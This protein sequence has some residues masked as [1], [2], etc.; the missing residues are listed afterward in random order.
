MEVNLAGQDEPLFGEKR[1]IE[2]QKLKTNPPLSE[3]IRRLVN[4]ELYAVLCTQMQGQPYGSLVAFAFSD[5]LKYAVFCTPVA[6]RKFRALSECDR[7]AVV[8]DSRV[9]HPDDM[10]LVEGITATGRATRLEPGKM[11]DKWAKLL[12][13]RHPHLSSFVKAPSTALFKIAIIRF[14]HVRRFQEVSQWIPKT[15]S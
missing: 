3:L 15:G 13:N 9:R 6:T 1:D 5:D 7:V 11:F 12:T 8:I 10:M 4:K 14:F 2:P